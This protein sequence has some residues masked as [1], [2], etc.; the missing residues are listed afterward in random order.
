MGKRS[1]SQERIKKRAQREKWSTD[2]KITNR[3]KDRIRKKS[4]RLKYKQR[5]E[6][7]F[8]T[9]GTVKNNK[10]NTR[11]LVHICNQIIKKFIRCSKYEQIRKKII[12]ERWNAML[13]SGL[14]SVQ[15]MSE[16]KMK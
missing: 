7:M 11:R 12:L 15:E 10:T 3:N 4:T 16:M 1:R 2:K 14:W 8:A 5:K 9:K 6:K 13:G